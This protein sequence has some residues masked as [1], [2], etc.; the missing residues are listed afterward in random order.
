[1][2]TAPEAGPTSA[3]TP[4]PTIQDWVHLLRTQTHQEFAA[5]ALLQEDHSCPPALEISGAAL[6]RPSQMHPYVSGEWQDTLEVQDY[7]EGI[8]R[9]LQ[10][11]PSISLLQ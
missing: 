7:L 10:L 5:F 8:F 2:N 6:I 11:D 9:L 4:I 1:M 3:P